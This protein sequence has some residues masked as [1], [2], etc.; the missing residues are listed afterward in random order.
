MP[1]KTRKQKLFKNEREYRDF[2]LKLHLSLIQ[3]YLENDESERPR[4]ED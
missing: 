1:R 2:L 4:H 3:L